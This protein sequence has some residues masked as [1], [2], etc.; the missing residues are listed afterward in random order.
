MTIL[1]KCEWW[2]YI[3]RDDYSLHNQGIC[4]KPAIT[5]FG[6]YLTCEECNQH[7]KLQ[8]VENKLD[9]SRKQK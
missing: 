7:L 3:S 9:Q 4:G 5:T 1:G 8:A 6:D 2:L